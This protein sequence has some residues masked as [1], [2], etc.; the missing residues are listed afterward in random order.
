MKRTTRAVALTAAL[1]LAGGATATALTFD[2]REDRSAAVASAIDPSTPKNVILLIGDGMG[3]SEI[4]AAR[5]YIG[6]MTA[7]LHMD[8]I[9]FRGVATPTRSTTP[10]RRGRTS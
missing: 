10:P 9:P 2:G 7:R 1:A 4:T 6:V 3:E 8:T 5:N